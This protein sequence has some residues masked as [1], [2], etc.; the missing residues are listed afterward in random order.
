MSW[1]DKLAST[2]TAGFRFNWHFASAN[3]ILESL[4]PII[5]PLVEGNKPQFT[6]TTQDQ[7]T[8]TIAANDGFIYSVTPSGIAVQFQH[9][10]KAQ[11]VSAGPPIMKM[12][13]QPMPYTVLL[14]EVLE[15]LFRA[16]MLI[17]G[18]RD[19]TITQFGIISLTIV[20]EEELPPGIGL[21]LDYLAKPWSA[22]AEQF[23]ISVTT[24]L[25][26]TNDWTEK[27]I[28]G[29]A[30]VDGQEELLILNF[31]WHRIYKKPRSLN[32]T[33]LKDIAKKCQPVA[34]E[35]FETLGEGSRFD[36]QI[37]NSQE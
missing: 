6:V 19:R 23:N 17:P 26:E 8:V 20:A 37:I 34:M 32:E 2:P 5:N 10:M 13:S 25:S 18:G 36:E 4:A 28:H 24:K 22:P 33:N 31:D 27:C 7:F 9:R 14:G 29:L 12:L 16:A 35:Y 3:A 21:F 11:Q 30:R 1:C 15:R